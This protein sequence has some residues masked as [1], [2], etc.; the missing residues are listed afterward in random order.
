MS[1]V[2]VVTTLERMSTNAA[3][4]LLR[5]AMRV[6]TRLL[7]RGKHRAWRKQARDQLRRR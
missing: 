1:L 7:G 6:L 4:A 3:A 2:R 5:A